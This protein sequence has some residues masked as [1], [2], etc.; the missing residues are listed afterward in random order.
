MARYRPVV[1]GQS[2]SELH[3]D[4]VAHQ[5][6]E[7]SELCLL[8]SVGLC[9]LLLFWLLEFPHLHELYLAV[10][11]DKLIHSHVA[12][13][14]SD[15]KSVVD[16]LGDDMPCS[17]HILAIT[18]PLDDISEFCVGLVDS[19]NKQDVDFVT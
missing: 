6:L 4:A 2:S 3:V 17:K 12:S 10:L 7:F 1:L 11:V 14:D 13:S 19:I 18:Q 5:L 15:Q 16:N 9:R 8:V